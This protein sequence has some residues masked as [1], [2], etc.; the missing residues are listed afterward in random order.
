MP[1]IAWIFFIEVSKLPARADGSSIIDVILPAN[2]SNLPDISDKSPAKSNMSLLRLISPMAS[3]MPAMLFLA[4]ANPLENASLN[5]SVI[6]VTKFAIT[7]RQMLLQSLPDRH[8]LQS[9][10]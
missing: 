2:S 1:V 5:W 7:F 4:L 9:P 10:A 3:F 8:L 6:D